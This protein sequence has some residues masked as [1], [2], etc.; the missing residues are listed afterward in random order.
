MLSHWC[1]TVSNI[2]RSQI[3]VRPVVSLDTESLLADFMQQ[4]AMEK[5]EKDRIKDIISYI[6]ML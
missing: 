2:N 1:G 3:Q 6:E 4:S 5:W